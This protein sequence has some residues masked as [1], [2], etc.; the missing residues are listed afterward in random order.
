MYAAIVTHENDNTVEQ[1][2]ALLPNVWNIQYQG[3][4]ELV[5][6]KGHKYIVLWGT[7]AQVNELISAREG[8]WRTIQAGEFEEID[9]F[10]YAY[11]YVSHARN[12]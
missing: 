3:E 12:L 8:E 2:F 7:E 9:F 10:S 4:Y 6:F 1:G 11:G 5:E